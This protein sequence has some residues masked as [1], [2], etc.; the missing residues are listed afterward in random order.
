MQ[1]DSY[2][3]AV[4][5]PG[6]GVARLD[7][8]TIGY[9]QSEQVD[10]ELIAGI[11]FRAK[12]VD[13]ET[14]EPVSGLRLSHWQNKK[15][16]GSS[17]ADGVISIPEML[18]GRFDFSVA[19][20]GYARW[21]SA[22]AVSAW[23]QKSID[24]AE[25]SWQR[26]FDH[27]DFEISPDRQSV[28]ITVEKGVRVRGR[29]I[30]PDGNPVG[31][32]T[33]APAL[34]GTGNSLTGD[35]RFSVRTRPDGTFEMLLPAS[36]EARYNLVAHDGGYQQWRNWAN[37][38]LEPVQTKPGE[39]IEGVE[40]QLTHGATVRGRVVD[41]AGKAVPYREVRASAADKLENRYYDPTV[42]TKADGTFELPFIRPGDQ[43]IQV[44]PFWL[45]AEQAPHDSSKTV[46]LEAGQIQDGIELVGQEIR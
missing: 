2:E 25:L 6:F 24:K 33:A 4:E 26:N 40:I 46:T 8:R 13:S 43:Y 3:L 17:G 30:D 36:N 44:A 18:P 11:T 19:A 1:P 31:G 28:T 27:L 12:V 15:V 34:T 41:A 32:A 22:E 37:G 10:V 20:K 5:A 14:G 23:N 39:E 29:V 7:R 21:W 16:A 38:V 35:T 9:A 42:K 45:A